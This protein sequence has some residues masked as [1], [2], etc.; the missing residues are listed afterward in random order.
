[1]AERPDIDE[2]EIPEAVA[3]PK[4]RW[5]VQWVWLLPIV[6]A[7]IG[8]WLAVRAV[9]SDGPTVTIRFKTAEGVEPGKTRIKYKDVDIGVVKNIT[10]DDDRAGV[11]VKADLS[12]AAEDL[13]VEDTRFWV[14][15]ARIAGG[16]VSGIGTLLSGSYIGMDPGKSTDSRRDFVGLESPPVITTGLAGKQFVLRAEDIG[17]L[18]VGS[19]VYFRRLEAG[20][21]IAYDLDKDGAAVFVRIFVN[22]PYDKYVTDNARFWHASGI[23]V[24]LDASGLKF[25]TE[26]LA[27]VLIGGLAFQPPDGVEPYPPA[28]ENAVFRLFPDRTAAMKEPISVS[29]RYALVFRE[30]VRGLAEGAPVDFRGILVG[31]VKTITPQFDRQKKEFA[32]IAE[33]DFFPERLFRSRQREGVAPAESGPSLARLVE[34]G[35]RAQLRAANLL[36]GQLFVSLDFVPAAQKVAMD[37]S[38]KPPE[39]PTVPGSTQELQAQIGSIAR[40]LDSVPYQEIGM[41]LRR[42]LQISSAML[43]RVD[44]DITPEV[45]ETMIE[46]RKA[47]T[48]AREALVE[49]RKALTAVERTLADAAPLPVEASD[50]LREISRAAQSFRTLADYLERHPEAVI[51]G[52]REETK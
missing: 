41:E 14:V 21:V 32:V 17:S 43:E 28:A 36:T 47:M 5:G 4:R 10:L 50:A 26:S 31:E 33:I 1:M 34:R 39:V 23:D 37:T 45:R 24:A 15:R 7:I 6:A 2:D 46:A 25:N 8:G 52:K 19:P 16:T 49:A 9:L 51:R 18:D 35:L 22:A 3:V 20:R 13:V 30:S 38:R 48:E 40:K 29:E 11:V 27:S 12:K 42:T 44:R